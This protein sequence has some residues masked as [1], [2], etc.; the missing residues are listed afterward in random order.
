MLKSAVDAGA[1]DGCTK[2][3]SLTVD[4]LSLEDNLNAFMSIKNIT[5]EALKEQYMRMEL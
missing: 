1:V 2:K 5:A 4:G 3:R